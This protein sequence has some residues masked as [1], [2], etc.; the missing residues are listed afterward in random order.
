MNSPEPKPTIGRIVI[1]RSNIGDGPIDRAALVTDVP[2]IQGEIGV[3]IFN[4]SNFQH[5]IEALSN[6]PFDPDGK[7]LPSWRWPG[8]SIEEVLLR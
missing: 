6:V 8:R 3:A 5:R 4:P 2:P 1:V 7:E